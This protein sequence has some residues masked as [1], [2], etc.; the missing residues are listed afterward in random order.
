MWYTAR[1]YW[2]Q[3]KP[4]PLHL[5]GENYQY[6]FWDIFFLGGVPWL[7]K[8]G[9]HRTNGMSLDCGRKADYNFPHGLIQVMKD[10]KTANLFLCQRFLY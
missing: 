2:G 4:I 1:I 7:H 8:V 9:K 6:A 5:A 10:W 3:T